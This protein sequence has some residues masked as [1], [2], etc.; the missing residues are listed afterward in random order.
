MRVA[1]STCGTDGLGIQY[2][3]VHVQGT[4]VVTICADGKAYSLLTD[5]V[6]LKIGEEIGHI[7]FSSMYR[8]TCRETQDY[9]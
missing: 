7:G 1:H 9:G 5:V 4:E 2:R 3:L 8:Q 6:A